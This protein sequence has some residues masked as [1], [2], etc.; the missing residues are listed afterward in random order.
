M[1]KFNSLDDSSCKGLKLIITSSTMAESF[2]VGVDAIAL[3]PSLMVL[4]EINSISP[5][6]TGRER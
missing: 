4:R 6:L 3:F 5:S 1:S 2:S